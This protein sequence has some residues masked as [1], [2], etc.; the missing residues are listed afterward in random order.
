MNDYSIESLC[1]IFEKHSNEYEES[2]RKC[3]ETYKKLYPDEDLAPHLVD[4][5]NLSKALKVICKKIKE[6]DH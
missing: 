1:K 6:Y 3:I 5:F 2:N 4:S